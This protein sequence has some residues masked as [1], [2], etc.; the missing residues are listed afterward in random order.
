VYRQVLINTELE[1]GKT[2]QKNRADWEKSIKEAR[3][4]IGL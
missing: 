4:S 1:T 2:G 3:V